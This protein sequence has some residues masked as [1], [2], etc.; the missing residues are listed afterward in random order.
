MILFK[1]AWRNL[2]RSKRRTWITIS[3]V[4]F[5]VLLAL[6]L[7]SMDRGSQEVMVQNVVRFSTGYAQL[8]DTLYHDESHIDNAMYCDDDCMEKILEDFPN[9]EYTV[10][11]LESVALAA[12][13]E[14]TRVG[15]ITGIDYESENRFNNI[16]ERLRDGHFFTGGE[17]EVVIG[18][19]LARSL[20]LEVG[21]SMVVF[22]QGFQGAMAAGKF[23]VVGLVQHP[24]P[25]LNERI[26]Y[27]PLHQA[28]WLFDAYDRVNHLKLVPQRL[29]H[30]QRVVDAINA[31]PDYE[32]FR[33]FTWE[34]LQPELVQTIEFD[35]A[36]TLM[37][38]LILYVI[39]GFGIFGTVLTMTLER[40]KEFGV[41][42]SVGMQRRK[43]AQVIFTET[44][45]MNF[46]GVLFGLILSIPVLLYFYYNPIPLGEGMED[47]MAEYG[48]EAVLR[49]SL[50]PQFFY[51][52]AIIVFCISMAIVAYPVIRVFRLDVL[53]AA[54][55]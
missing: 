17:D 10:P 5:A 1:L 16:G 22:G 30:H 31:H 2:W 4:L 33:A 40:E 45:I 29:R 42:I 3:S 14:K 7:E 19:G 52:Q 11:R 44:L 39:I 34:E 21:D 13:D 35:Q 18:T 12:G 51:Q 15:F 9:L 26:V 20:D 43:L 25:D 28:Q 47:M 24:V 48:M 8:Q 50:D 46:L 38:L 23:V 6:F 55:K 41:L 32:A 49:F 54:R 27:M 36:G 37:F 53:K